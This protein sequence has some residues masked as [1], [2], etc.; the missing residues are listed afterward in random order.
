MPTSQKQAPK[1]VASK[2]RTP[3]KKTTTS[4]DKK[5]AS[6]KTP[7]RVQ[8]SNKPK[9][10]PAKKVGGGVFFDSVYIDYKF[11]EDTQS[12][13]QP[14][15]LNFEKYNNAVAYITCDPDHVTEKETRPL[16]LNYFNFNLEDNVFKLTYMRINEDRFKNREI[17]KHFDIT[18]GNK[19][20][21]VFNYLST[22]GKDGHA[23]TNIKTNTHDFEFSYQDKPPNKPD[24]YTG[25]YTSTGLY[26][27]TAVLYTLGEK[28]S[29][30]QVCT[31]I[32]CAIKKILT[33]EKKLN[34][35]SNLNGYRVV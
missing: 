26:N 15:P 28:L 4:T 1:T 3:S 9:R 35:K 8:K 17:L 34:P 33:K 21:I 18:N 10:S 7:K 13:S 11:L 24:D 31:N 12:W 5:T 29:F 20:K 23:I 22:Y 16:A 6:G 25:L 2:K 14:R 27:S 32:G 30:S 19:I